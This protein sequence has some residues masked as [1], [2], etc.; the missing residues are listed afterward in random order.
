[1]HLSKIVV[2]FIVPEGG[3]EEHAACTTRM[4]SFASKTEVK[5]N[6]TEQDNLYVFIH[7]LIQGRGLFIWSRVNAT[8]VM[9]I[10][11][12]VFNVFKHLLQE[13]TY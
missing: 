13:F 4:Y 11:L 2:R 12:F 8:T 3:M 10:N 1:M 5:L 7:V 6:K 9:I